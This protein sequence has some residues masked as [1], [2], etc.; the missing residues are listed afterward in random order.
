MGVALTI[1]MTSETKIGIFNENM[2]G[3]KLETALALKLEM[4]TGLTLKI[5]AGPA[6]IKMSN[7][8]LESV[9]AKIKAIMGPCVTSAAARVS[10]G[11]L[12]CYLP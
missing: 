8:K 2:I 10:R 3:G 11:S 7:A 1:G 9:Q 12:H 5:G 6:E 4:C